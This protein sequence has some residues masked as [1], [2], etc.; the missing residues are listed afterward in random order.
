MLTFVLFSCM[1]TLLT[2]KHQKIDSPHCQ[3]H[4]HM[5]S[6]PYLFLVA[7]LRRMA[8]KLTTHYLHDGNRGECITF[9]CKGSYL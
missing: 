7:E 4:T 8:A 3:Q 1:V 6:S 2:L 5:Y 9:V